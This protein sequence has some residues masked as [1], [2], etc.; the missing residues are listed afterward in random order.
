MKHTIG[1]LR[2]YLNIFRYNTQFVFSSARSSSVRPRLRSPIQHYSARV[3]TNII[4]LIGPIDM[5]S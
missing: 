1:A 5:I 3:I 2:I 4:H